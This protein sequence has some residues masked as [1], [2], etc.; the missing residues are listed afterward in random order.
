VLKKDDKV[1]LRLP[2]EDSQQKRNLRPAVVLGVE[3]DVCV[4][5]LEEPAPGL[6]AELGAFLHFEE[7]RKFV[8]QSIKVIG[9]ESG[10]PAVVSVLLQ[11]SPVSAES[12]Q[13]FRVSCLSANIKAV[14]ADEAGCDVVDLSTTGFAFYGRVERDIGRRVQVLLSYDGKEYRGQGTIQ[15]SRRMNTGVLR[16]GVHCTDGKGDDLARAL[17]TVSLAVQSEQLR[18]LSKK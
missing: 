5:Q 10:T 12:R 11:G 18:R 6:E 7:R 8:Q 13:A 3:E 14:V 2:K 1:F 17:P 9:R 4:I 15:S 16:Y